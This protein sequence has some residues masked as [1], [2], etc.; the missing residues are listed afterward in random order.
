MFEVNLEQRLKDLEKASSEVVEATL[1]KLKGMFDELR[2]ELVV[3]DR[4]I[5]TARELPLGFSPAYLV[6]ASPL[7]RAAKKKK[8]GKNVT[9]PIVPN[10]STT[11]ETKYRPAT[12]IMVAQSQVLYRGRKLIMTP[13]AMGCCVVYGLHVGKDSQFCSLDPVPAEMFSPLSYGS[14]MNMDTAQIGMFISLFVSNIGQSEISVTA[15]LM[16][17]AVY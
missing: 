17:T 8:A 5:T 12:A 2:K 1:G 10:H 14:D 15:G 3:V 11:H 4:P 13:S 16:G 9:E 6:P 7:D